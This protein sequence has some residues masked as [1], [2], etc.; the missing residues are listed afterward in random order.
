MLNPTACVCEKNFPPAQS[1]RTSFTTLSTPCDPT[2]P[3]RSRSAQRHPARPF[4]K[5]EQAIELR[6]C[7]WLAWGGAG[8]GHPRAVLVTACCTATA[9]AAHHRLVHAEVA[10]ARSVGGACGARTPAKSFTR[11][12]ASSLQRSP[13]SD[14]STRSRCGPM[15]YLHTRG[16]ASY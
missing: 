7:C 4:G 10:A 11:R 15:F 2:T 16:S 6:P 12:C 3:V 1:I 8:H 5:V 14:P 13:I 9:K